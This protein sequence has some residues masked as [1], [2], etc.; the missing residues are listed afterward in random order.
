MHV[1]IANRQW[2]GKRSRHFRRMH[3]PRGGGGGGG[4]TLSLRISRYVPRFC[5]SFLASGRSFCP[6]KFDL[7]YHF[8]QILLGPISKPPNFSMYTIFLP[9]KRPNLSFYSDLVGSH[10]ELRAVHP[11]WFWPGVPPPPSPNLI[12]SMDTSTKS[13]HIDA[14]RRAITGSSF[15]CRMAY[16]LLGAKPLL[17]PIVNLLV[18]NKLGVKIQKK[19]IQEVPWKTLSTKLEA[20][21]FSHQCIKY[22]YVGSTSESNIVDWT[23]V[24]IRTTSRLPDQPYE[25]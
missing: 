17:E 5:P 18:Q 11:Y 23:P 20:I 16:C 19:I 14:Y 24:W 8:I 22:A 21:S 7:V 13:M 12:Y 9:P 6:Q 1:G 2:W 10:F 4:G 3:N 15:V 25:A